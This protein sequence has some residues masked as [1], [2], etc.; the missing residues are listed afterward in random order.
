[1]TGA[2]R[3]L[4]TVWNRERRRVI[5]L[6]P[7][8]DR[9]G[10]AFEVLKYLTKVADFSDVPEAVEVFANAVKGA[11]LIQTFGTWYGAKLDTSTDFDPEKFED[12][13]EMKCACGVKDRKSTR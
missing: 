5:D 10:A 2:A 6:R 13:G 11:R 12:W 3:E 7:V 8:T 9:G 4:R 1:M